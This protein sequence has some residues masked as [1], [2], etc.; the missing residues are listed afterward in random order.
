LE[1]RL[2]PVF[3]A[4]RQSAPTGRGYRKEAAVGTRLLA[5]WMIGLFSAG[6]AA[7]Q[8]ADIPPTGPAGPA[9]PS[10]AA[11]P[12]AVAPFCPPECPPEPCS[13]A[14]AE[15]LWWNI[16][17]GP[18][19]FP[20][21]TLG[22]TFAAGAP[23]GVPG[24]TVLLGNGDLDFN[25]IPGLRLSAGNWLDRGR[26]FGVEA[27]AFILFQDRISSVLGSDAAGSPL[28]SRPF[29]DPISGTPFA[30]V[31]SSP[32]AFTGALAMT[33]TSRLWGTDTNVRLALTRQD[34]LRVD[35]LAGVRFLNLTEKVL[36]EQRLDTVPGSGAPILM[37]DR[38]YTANYFLGGQVGADVEYSSG[39]WFVGVV[40]KVAAGVTRSRVEV[41]GNGPLIGPGNFGVRHE[42]KFGLVSEAEFRLGCRL[43]ECVRA[44]VGYNALCWQQVARPGD[45]ID[46][47]V[48]P[49]NL[50]GLP[51]GPTR[52]AATFRDTDFWAHGL[53]LGVEVRY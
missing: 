36:L 50:L 9:A 30:L 44:Y 1:S 46:P 27:G 23:L 29:L 37:N 22:G 39:M 14:R 51:F 20:L 53:T 38:F 11:D 43:T 45:Q 13:W 47:V 28:V 4:V 26:T 10:L 16:E 24:S 21:A 41:S 5:A 8:S 52:P 12:A 31:V 33:A 42:N 7:G 25:H 15:F 19:P 6:L 32:G 49:A 35:G 2:Q 40:G 3:A 17:D 34:G 18:L 48:N